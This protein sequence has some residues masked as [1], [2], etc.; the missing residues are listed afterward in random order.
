MKIYAGGQTH[1]AAPAFEIGLSFMSLMYWVFVSCVQKAAGALPLRFL[2]AL[3]VKYF[4][5]GRRAVK[6]SLMCERWLKADEPCANGGSYAPKRG[7]YASITYETLGTGF[8]FSGEDFQNTGTLIVVR[9]SVFSTSTAYK[10]HLARDAY[11][12]CSRRAGRSQVQF[13]QSFCVRFQT[14]GLSLSE[15]HFRIISI[16][17]NVPRSAAHFRT[18]L[19]SFV[20]SDCDTSLLA[21]K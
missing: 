16:P 10:T 5:D 11:N 7:Q 4:I 20:Q 15:N 2:L 18:F 1:G 8:E 19:S 14:R 9:S 6:W 13:F 21:A 17:L 3:T 12:A